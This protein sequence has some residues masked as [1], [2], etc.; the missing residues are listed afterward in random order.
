SS[1]ILISAIVPSWPVPGPSCHLIDRNRAIDCCI[2][3]SFSA[4]FESEAIVTPEAIAI[5]AKPS[6]SR[7]NKR[8]RPLHTE[9]HLITVSFQALGLANTPT[10]PP[11]IAPTT[12]VAGRNR[13]KSQPAIV[14]PITPN[15]A[16]AA[17]IAARGTPAGRMA[18]LGGA[19]S[20]GAVIDFGA[21]LNAARSAR[22]SSALA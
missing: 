7:R 9:E 1:G 15:S 10:T 19:T 4:F 16:P 18:S 21:R 11:T 8:K 13:C 17:I 6:V 22:T 12:I 2:L 5:T 3:G 14:P 20:A